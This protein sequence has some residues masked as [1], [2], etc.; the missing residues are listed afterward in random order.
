MSTNEVLSDSP[1]DHDDVSLLEQYHEE[2]ADY[3]KELAS[4]YEELAALDLDDSDELV[5]HTKLEK[6]WFDCSHKVKKLLSM[7]VLKSTSTHNV[8]GKGVRLP[9]LDIPTVNGDVL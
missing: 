2:S 5:L 9:K 4:V 1:E 8:D 6:L 3:K 7:H